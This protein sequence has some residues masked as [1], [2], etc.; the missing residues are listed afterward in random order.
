MTTYT[1]K[2]LYE[3][4]KMGKEMR[5]R[6]YV[7]EKIKSIKD[8]IYEYAEDGM[9]NYM[10]YVKQVFVSEIIASVKESY[11]EVR[12]TCTQLRGDDVLATFDWT[13]LE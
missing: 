4:G 11:P 7:E 5:D 9:T 12:S 13:I 10:T 3:L 6:L 8:G 1:N 2:Q